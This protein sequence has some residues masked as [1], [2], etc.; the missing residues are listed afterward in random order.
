[1]IPIYSASQK[2]SASTKEKQESESLQ[3]QSHV[4]APQPSIDKTRIESH[5][6]RFHMWGAQ[7][8][9]QIGDPQPSIVPG[10]FDVAVQADFGNVF[11]LNDQ[12][13][14]SQDG[15]VLLRANMIRVKDD[16][17]Q[18]NLDK[19]N[20]NNQPWFGDPNGLVTVVVFSDFQCPFCRTEGLTL[21]E[22]IPTAYPKNVRVL[23]VDFPLEKLHPWSRPAAMLGR[24][25]YR[26]EPNKFWDYHDWLFRHQS[27]I[28]PDN[29]MPKFESF[30]RGNLDIVQI[31]QCLR[32]EKIAREIDDSIAMGKAL[33]I[34]SLSTVFVNGRSLDNPS[35]NQLSSVIDY[36]LEYKKKALES[37]N[38]S[39]PTS[40]EKKD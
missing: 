34:A 16:L 5:V 39:L 12:W 9:I 4:S 32:D 37:C 24:C 18:E 1:M 31:K 6:R 15:Q 13:F 40:P 28:T 26:Q 33:R 36:E 22:K 23:F 30:A 10:L 14:V 25:A 27:D 17:F 11:R 20:T 29:L 7:V 35:W 3:S 19:L 21:R 8:H 2:K 38:C